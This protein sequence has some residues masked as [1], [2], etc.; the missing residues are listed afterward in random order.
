MIIE[1]ITTAFKTVL[2][3]ILGFIHIPGMPVEFT[4]AIDNF[5]DLIFQNVGLLGLVVHW[6]TVK[7]GLPILIAV[8]NLDKIYDGIIWIIKK[9]PMAGM[10]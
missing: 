1:A 10:S 7:I 4:A 6:N 8:A 9:I 2:Q 3:T 5:F